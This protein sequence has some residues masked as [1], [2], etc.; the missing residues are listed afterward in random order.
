MDEPRLPRS[1]QLGHLGRLDVLVYGIV[2]REEIRELITRLVD[3]VGYR[4]QPGQGDQVAVVELLP[5]I[6]GRQGGIDEDSHAWSLA[7]VVMPGPLVLTLLV[8]WCR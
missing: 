8:T 5:E 3:E 6:V 1:E 7:S 2:R 4:L